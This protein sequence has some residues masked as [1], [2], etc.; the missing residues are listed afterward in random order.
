MAMPTPPN[1]RSDPPRRSA[2]PLIALAVVGVFGL[3]MIAITIVAV[4]FVLAVAF[5]A[6]PPE[7]TRGEAAAGVTVNA[8][9]PAAKFVVTS[10]SE[11]TYESIDLEVSFEG[12]TG[13]ELSILSVGDSRNEHQRFRVGQDDDAWATI[14][15]D[16]AAEIEVTV[17]NIDETGPVTL[18]ATAT[19]DRSGLEP[20][21]LLVEATASARPAPAGRLAVGVSRLADPN[22]HRYRIE[23][24]VPADSDSPGLDVMS[25]AAPLDSHN[26]PENRTGEPRRHNQ[27]TTAGARPRQPIPLAGGL[28]R[29]LPSQ[30]CR[31][32]RRGLALARHRH[33]RSGRP[34]DRGGRQARD[35]RDFDLV[36]AG[37]STV[38]ERKRD[39]HGATSRHGRRT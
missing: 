36:D 10:D 29:S 14:A 19:G 24:S 26:N 33:Q 21:T 17:V 32:L 16:D 31:W 7:T 11:L 20:P 39:V 37:N 30:H 22:Y 5:T 4:V 35:G 9:A 3:A 6:G 13:P 12:D 23:A 8:D 18:R 34:P 38:R 25:L 28:R 15:F 1:T 2:A 27:R